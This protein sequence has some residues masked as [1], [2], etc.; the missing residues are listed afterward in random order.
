MTV[1]SERSGTGS[2]CLHPEAN[3]S[4]NSRIRNLEL[5]HQAAILLVSAEAATSTFSGRRSRMGRSHFYIC[6][7]VTC[8]FDG[9]YEEELLSWYLGKQG[10]LCMSFKSELDSLL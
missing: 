2:D 10:R 9:M 1:A 6:E 8:V 7:M 3:D 4:L 5:E